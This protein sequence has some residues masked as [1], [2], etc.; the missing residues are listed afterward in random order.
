MALLA[1]WSWKAGHRKIMN[2]AKPGLW[3]V[4]TRKGLNITSHYWHGLQKML[5]EKISN[6]MQIWTMSIEYVIEF[7]QPQSL[8]VNCKHNFNEIPITQIELLYFL[9]FWI[10]TFVETFG[11]TSHLSSFFTF[12]QVCSRASSYHS[13]LNQS[14]KHWIKLLYSMYTEGLHQALLTNTY[15]Y[16]VCS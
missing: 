12:F 11:S 10:S 9:I 15:V 14:L 16:L 5:F 7:R 13:N 3:H 8:K 4:L 1:T 2:G 6:K